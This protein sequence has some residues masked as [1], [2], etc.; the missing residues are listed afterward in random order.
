MTIKKD[1]WY[2]G[3][4]INDPEYHQCILSHTGEKII[5][6]KYIRSDGHIFGGG[7]WTKEEG[8]NNYNTLWHGRKY[9]GYKSYW[10]YAL[11]KI[12]YC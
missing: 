5:M 4:H 3:E 7:D 1:S 12:K 11:V 6:A 8:G 2:L 9:Y 10:Q